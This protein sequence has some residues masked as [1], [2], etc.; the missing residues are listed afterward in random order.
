MNFTA[1]LN[2]KWDLSRALRFCAQT[3]PTGHGPAVAVHQTGF[4]KAQ[5]TN[6]AFTVNAFTLTDAPGGWS[7]RRRPTANSGGVYRRAH[8][9]AT[10]CSSGNLRPGKQPAYYPDY[11]YWLPPPPCAAGKVNAATASHA[12]CFRPAPS[13]WAASQHLSC[14]SSTTPTPHSLRNARAFLPTHRGAT[15]ALVHTILF[16]E[17]TLV[18]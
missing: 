9:R 15:C 6:L 5:S 12:R 4:S 8:T 7:W 14:H 16:E 2:K 18:P 3:K 1:G 17:V 10:S 13:K 11:Y